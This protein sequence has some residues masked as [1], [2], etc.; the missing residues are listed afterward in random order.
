MIAGCSIRLSTPPRLS[1]SAKMRTASR[2][3]RAPARSVFRSSE[4]MPP[5]PCIWRRRE[6]VLRMRRAGRGSAPA[7]TCGCCSQPLRQRE[8]VRAVPLHAQRQRLH[9]AQREEAVERARRSRRPRSAGSPAARAAASW[10]ASRADDGDAADHVG[11]AVQVLG[12]RVHDDVEA[13]LE[14][15]LHAGAGEGVVGH[16]RGCRARGRSRRSRAGRP[17]CS[18]GLVGVSTQTMLR[19]GRERG[20]AAAPGRSGRRS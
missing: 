15:P 8:R 18:S 3:R 12:G 13:E 7:S 9:A 10:R 5:K 14:R 11:V 17:A 16:A 1:A 19:L 6:R 4:I 2:K 20:L